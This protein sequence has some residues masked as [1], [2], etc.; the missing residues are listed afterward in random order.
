MLKE[1]AWNTF[2]KTG[3]IDV[4]LEFLRIQ[5]IEQNLGKQVGKY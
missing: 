1:I 3:N 5:N 2:K 4:Y